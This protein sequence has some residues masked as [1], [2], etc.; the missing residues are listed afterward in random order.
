MGKHMKMT[1]EPGQRKD[2]G[3]DLGEHLAKC[4]R[5]KTGNQKEILGI[6]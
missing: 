3:F 2:L 4:R 6:T 5:L 1:W